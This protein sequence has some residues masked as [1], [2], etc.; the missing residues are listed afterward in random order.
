M[1]KNISYEL[2]SSNTT[3]AHSLVT[4]VAKIHHCNFCSYTTKYKSNIQSHLNVHAGT[5]P[6][7]CPKCGKGFS[8]R[9]NSNRHVAK[10]GV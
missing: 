7:T 10:C 4:P 9:S 3:S 6:F 5:K 8:H 2:N 1:W